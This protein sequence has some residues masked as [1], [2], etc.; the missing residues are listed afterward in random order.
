[1]YFRLPDDDPVGF[2]FFVTEIIA[3]T[4]A[5]WRKKFILFQEIYI[6]IGTRESRVYIREHNC[7]I[8]NGKVEKIIGTDCFMRTREF[9][10]FV[11]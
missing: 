2:S 9:C 3:N 11:W 6:S 5:P 1:M 4:L 8:P 10:V 7:T